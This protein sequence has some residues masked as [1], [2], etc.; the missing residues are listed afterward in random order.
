MPSLFPLP[1][2]P[3]FWD[4]WLPLAAARPLPPVLDPAK[5]DPDPGF[6]VTDVLVPVPVPVPASTEPA[7]VTALPPP[8]LA[9]PPG[10]EYPSSA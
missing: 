6:P 4:M 8:G 10:R 1:F 9:P 5:P 2:L 3:A 7:L